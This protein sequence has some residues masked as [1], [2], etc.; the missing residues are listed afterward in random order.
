MSLVVSLAF[1]GGA[2]SPALEVQDLDSS[3][4]IL[5]PSSHM[6]REVPLFPPDDKCL[7]RFNRTDATIEE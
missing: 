2:I 5:S 1:N 3:S 6:P 7:A 4:V